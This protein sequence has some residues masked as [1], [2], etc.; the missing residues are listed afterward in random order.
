MPEARKPALVVWASGRILV[1]A[2]T[3]RILHLR[4][5]DRINI[6]T[7]GEEYCVLRITPKAGQWKCLLR[8]TNRRSRGGS[9]YLYSKPLAKRLLMASNTT[10]MVR[11]AAGEPMEIEGV[12]LVLPLITRNPIRH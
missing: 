3:T 7:N 11:L 4:E 5:G 2:W 1:S 6:V 10:E 12:G 9:L 8:R